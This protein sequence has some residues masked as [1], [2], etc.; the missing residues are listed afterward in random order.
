MAR[1]AA[2]AFA[3]AGLL[4]ASMTP[5]RADEALI[6]DG[7]HRIGADSIKSYFQAS[8]GGHFTDADVDAAVK[9]MYAS[10]EFSDVTTARQGGVLHVHVGENPLITR[11]AFEGNKKITDKQATSMVTSRQGDPLSRPVVQEDVQ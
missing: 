2:A 5:A 1:R 3:L 10:G 8:A 11:V 6:I 7:N 9:A 4:C